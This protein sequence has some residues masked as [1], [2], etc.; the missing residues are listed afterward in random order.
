MGVDGIETDLRLDSDGQL[1][2]FHDRHTPDHRPIHSVSRQELSR[3]C[4]YQVPT[5]EEAL[6]KFP[7]L[8]WNL[9][10]KT[11]E[12][13]PATLDL[14]ERYRASHRLLITSFWHTVIREVAQACD[15]ECGLLLCHRPLAAS[16]E[17]F[18]PLGLAAVERN[19]PQHDRITSLVWCYEFL[20]AAAIEEAWQAGFRNYCYSVGTPE[21]H[22]HC[23]QLG[24]DGLITDRPEFA[25]PFR[26]A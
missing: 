1:I 15:V 18:Q 10:I 4:E 5:A 13:L 14:I 12:A 23:E 8:L 9:E 17:P 24:L 6:E 16:S 19:Q 21:E 2:L 25:L 22:R 20:D 11:P 26:G 3:L 7:H